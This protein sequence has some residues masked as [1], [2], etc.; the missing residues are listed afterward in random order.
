L[1]R[2]SEHSS[3]TRRRR[4]NL[5]A[6]A[7]VKYY[8]ARPHSAEALSNDACLTTSVCRTSVCRVHRPKSRAE[9]PRKTK[10]GTEVAHVT[11]HS[12]ITFKVKRSKVNLQGAEH[13]AA[14]SRT[15]WY[16]SAP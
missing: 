5:L 8:Y 10:I 4:L 15:A 2:V 1:S 14:V 16:A 7:L 6:Y 13:I 12:D 11:R 9:R 3:F